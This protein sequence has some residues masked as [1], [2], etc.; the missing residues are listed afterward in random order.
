MM[1]AEFD[2]ELERLGIDNETLVDLIAYLGDEPIE[3]ERPG[4]WR[5]GANRVPGPV[6]AFIRVYGMLDGP[7]RRKLLDAAVAERS[8]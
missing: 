6:V 4:I 2:S 3:K 1:P 7:A 8:A 5:T